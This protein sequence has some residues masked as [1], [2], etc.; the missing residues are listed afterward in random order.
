MTCKPSSLS[1][2]NSVAVSP[3]AVM[4]VSPPSHPAVEQPVPSGS[5]SPQ[6][7][8]LRSTTPAP[9]DEDY[10]GLEPDA[11]EPDQA[12]PA[13]ADHLAD[14]VGFSVGYD[15]APADD[16]SSADADPAD[17]EVESDPVRNLD[18]AEPDQASP[19]PADHLAD[20]VR[21]LVGSDD[22]PADDA[23]SADSDVEVTKRM[24]WTRPRLTI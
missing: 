3:K 17:A 12:G 23:S 10:T 19:A 21:F 6:L 1:L 8:P 16:A 15:E 5:T 11:T 24:T 18:T 20:P 4:T 13:P 14:P 7:T 2:G 9:D 22:A